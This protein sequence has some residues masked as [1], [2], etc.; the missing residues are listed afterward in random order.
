MPQIIPTV[1]ETTT[2]ERGFLVTQP[3]A[4]DLLG[5]DV[6]FTIR[7]FTGGE[8]AARSV[9]EAINNFRGLPKD[10][11]ADAASAVFAYYKD[12]IAQLR[13]AGNE[14]VL[15]WI[16]RIS[17]PEEVWNH[18]TLD[19]VAVVAGETI[20]GEGASQFVVWSGD[21]IWEEDRG[22]AISFKNGSD[23]VKVGPNDGA[24]EWPAGAVDVSGDGLYR[25]AD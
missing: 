17:G 11:L 24:P 16:P 8:D 18:V 23:V 3:L 2:D 5:R 13:E 7:D 22:L 12:V 19:D 25:R 15:D 14:E 21:C 9:A 10:A 20:D 6:A 4:V 1:G